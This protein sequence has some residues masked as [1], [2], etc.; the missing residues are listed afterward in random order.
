MQLR[1]VMTHGK[2]DYQKEKNAHE[3]VIYTR[4]YQSLLNRILLHLMG[5][6]EYYIDYSLPTTTVKKVSKSAGDG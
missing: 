2:R 3:D 5:Y 6:D 4:V 1:N